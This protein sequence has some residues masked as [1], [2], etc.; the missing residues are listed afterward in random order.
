MSG[1]VVKQKV[2]EFS[3]TI[4]VMHQ[5][6]KSCQTDYNKSQLITRTYR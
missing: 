4:F 3:R 2:P 1:P 5:Q 6:T